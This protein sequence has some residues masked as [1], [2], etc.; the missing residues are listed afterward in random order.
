MSTGRKILIVS[1][2]GLIYDGITSVIIAY[3]DAMDRS[4]LEIYIAGTIEVKDA[5]RKKINDLGCTIVDFPNRK[6]E[7]GSYAIALT[8]FIRDNK[9]K[10]IHAH[11]NSGTLVIEMTAAWLGGCKKRIAHSHNTQ[12]SQIKA[13]RLL[14]PLFYL[15]YTDGLACGKEAGEWLFGNRAHEILPNGRD[16]EKYKFNS[17]IRDKFRRK[18]GIKDE[19]V[20]GHVGG[21][22]E[23]KNHH[24][25]VEIY[26]EI[27]ILQ[28]NTKLFMFGDGPT[29]KYVERLCE[30]IDVIFAGTTDNISDFLNMMDGM[31]LPSLFEGIPL[32]AIEWQI[33]G[34][35][36]ILSDTVTKDCKLTDSVLFMSLKRSASEWAENIITMIE[37]NDRMTCAKSA[38][39]TISTSSFNIKS[40]SEKLRE[41]Y[42][43]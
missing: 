33:N 23:Q 42:N 34:L 26:R 29:K 22:F 21:F 16:V 3:L 6:T 31:L 2:V 41:L 17:S 8:K 35:P 40:N 37:T 14:R 9:I 30:D 13:D 4:G 28:P 5:F 25:L 36:C 18:L 39:E 20:I 27:K 11:G 7:T 38:Y 15:L 19:I 1:T 10:V 24:F 43:D 32:V 12:C